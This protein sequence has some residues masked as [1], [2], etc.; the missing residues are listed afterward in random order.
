ML[1][2]VKNNM[3]TYRAF[4]LIELLVVIAIVGILAGLLL[5]TLARAKMVAKGVQN[6]NN[7]KQIASAFAMYVDDHGGL[8]VGIGESSGRYFFG[9]HKGA[10]SEVDFSGGYLSE[11]VNYSAK[12]W[13]DPVFVSVSKRAK[14]RTCSYAFNSHYLN[15]MEEQGNWWE[16]NYSYVYRGLDTQIMDAPVD[17]VLFGDSARNW[18]GPVEENW[19]WTPPSQAR[20]WAGWETAYTHFRHSGKATVLWGDGHVEMVS[21]DKTYPVNDDNLGYIC[22]IN[23]RFFKAVK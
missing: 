7:L 6:K 23:D 2:C 13:Q 9:K 1:F 20:A 8:A 22:D 10:G 14:G 18:M 21:P 15:E 4:T 11:Y 5:P 17:T 12:V 19:F 16:P 3:K